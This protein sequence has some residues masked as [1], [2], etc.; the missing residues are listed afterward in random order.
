MT[1]TWQ[2]AVSIALGNLD[3]DEGQGVGKNFESTLS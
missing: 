2:K 1:S 3:E